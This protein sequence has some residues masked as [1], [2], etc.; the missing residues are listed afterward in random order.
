MFGLLM[1]FGQLWAEPWD[2]NNS[3]FLQGLTTGPYH[4][5]LTGGSLLPVPWSIA[6]EIQTRAAIAL[7]D[8]P[9]RARCGHDQ[10]A[11]VGPDE[12]LP[13]AALLLPQT[14]E[15]IGGAHDNFHRPAAAILAHDGLEAQG[16]I[17]GEKGFDGWRGFSVPG[18]FDAMGSLAPYHHDSDERPGQHRVPQPTPRLHRGPGF[19]RMRCPA[20][21]S[22]GQ[23]CG[24]TDQS[25]FFVRGAPRRFGA[26]RGGGS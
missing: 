12:A 25:A 7:V 5:E 4:I 26:G 23:G 15:G 18:L 20:R 13:F 16:E 6:A 11:C 9:Q 19:A 1:I 22:A 3:S 10:T 8:A 2:G 17:S 21:R 24:R 14:V